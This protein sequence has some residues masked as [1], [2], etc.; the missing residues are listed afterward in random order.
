MGKSDT[1]WFVHD[2]FGM[3]IH[4]GIYAMPARH[5]WVKQREEMSDEKYDIYFKYFN[6]DLFDATQW[7]KIAKQ[8]GMKYAVITTKHHD[9]FCLFDSKYTDYKATNT[10]AKRDLIREF[11][12]AFR[13]EGLKI[14]FYY[15]LI[16]WHH[17]HFTIDSLHVLRNHPEREKLNQSRDMN[18]YR[19]YLHN[20]VRELL[21]NY[22]KID[23][24]WFDF[25]YPPRPNAPAD[26]VGKGR[27]DWDSEN[28][29]KLVR[30]LQPH[31]IMNNRL[32]LPDQW[33]FLTPEQIGVPEALTVDGKPVV[34]EAC[35]TFS[36]SW[37]YHRDEESWKSVDVLVKMLIDCVSKD[38]NLLLNVG[39]TARGEFDN[40]ALERLK[41]IGEW[42]R[43][44]SRSIY[45]CTKAPDE[46]KAPND[47]RLTY[48]P[49]TNRL[50]IHIFS[51]PFKFLKVDFGDRIEYAQLLNDGSEIPLQKIKYPYVRTADKE[52]EI[53]M[54][55]L[56]LPVKKPDVCVPVIEVFLK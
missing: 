55:T 19:E 23:I 24:I 28:L 51:W 32:D 17:P 42:M 49:E 46:F 13:S 39:P 16:D 37:G 35:H 38:G 22:G 44:H 34:W 52:E 9:G 36:G 2:R 33:D 5:E 47:C 8:A 45:G 26:W 20:Q 31:I 7:A 50:Y 14:G 1:R 27:Q 56:I 25:S 15:S 40:R 10:P 3:F 12:D 18:K 6:P 53:Q 43:Y 41:G 4:W 29:V 21:T 54:E 11:V 30:S 48:N